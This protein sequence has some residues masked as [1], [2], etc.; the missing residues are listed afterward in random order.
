MQFI[1][2]TIISAIIIASIATMS[3]KLPSMGAIIASLPLT[4]ILAMIWLYEDTKDITKVSSLSTSIFWIVIPSLVFFMVLPMFLK[5]N[6]NFY[7]SLVFSSMIMVLIYSI[8][9]FILKKFGI[10]I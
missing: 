7:L 8:Y 5:K 4:S 1:I 3:K 6:V 10:N 2:K 9:S